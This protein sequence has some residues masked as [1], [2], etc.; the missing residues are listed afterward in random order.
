MDIPID[1][2]AIYHS[3]SLNIQDWQTRTHTI[4]LYFPNIPCTFLYSCIFLLSSL[5]PDYLSNFMWLLLWLIPDGTYS[6]MPVYICMPIFCL[7]FFC[8][9]IVCMSIFPFRLE[10]WMQ[11][12]SDLFWSLIILSHCRC[13]TNNVTKCQFED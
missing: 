10:L 11:E 2:Q 3:Q 8:L 5:C 4:I 12:R 7:L 13:S 6:V 1:S 9:F